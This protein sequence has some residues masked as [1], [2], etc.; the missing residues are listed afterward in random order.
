MMSK[1]QQWLKWN[2]RRIASML[3]LV[4]ESLKHL[5]VQVEST[6][7][8]AWLAQATL[9]CFREFVSRPPSPHV[10]PLLH[11]ALCGF[12]VRTS[13][14]V[15]PF[16]ALET[17]RARAGRVAVRL[18][19][20]TGP[21]SIARAM[22]DIDTSIVTQNAHHLCHQQQR[23]AQ[24]GE[25]RPVTI[26]RKAGYMSVLLCT[27]RTM[28]EFALRDAPSYVRA[29]TGPWHRLM[30]LCVASAE[31]AK[32]ETA[33]QAAHCAVQVVNA[34]DV[35]SVF[36]M[37][38]HVESLPALFAALPDCLQCCAA[39]CEEEVRGVLNM[40]TPDVH[41]LVHVAGVP[42]RTWLASGAPIPAHPLCE[43]GGEEK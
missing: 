19:D 32:D 23:Q 24:R 43:R 31:E 11:A 5:L 1:S 30:M 42:S 7:A 40:E 26:Y 6:S 37:V 21:A 20:G 27:C 38:V 2:V 8:S 39:E 10:D 18:F 35:R 13:G 16:C 3:P 36:A 34:I 41:D 4:S 29:S 22:A 15:V 12:G 28:C 9:E 17:A 25:R 14:V 33:M